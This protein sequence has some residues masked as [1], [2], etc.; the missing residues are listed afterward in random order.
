MYFS[1][2]GESLFVDYKKE[3]IKFTEIILHIIDLY[4]VLI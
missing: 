3:Y 1:S 2:D 4:E